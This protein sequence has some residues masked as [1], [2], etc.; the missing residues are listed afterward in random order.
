MIKP[1]IVESKDSYLLNLRGAKQL[2][3]I[4][5]ERTNWKIYDLILS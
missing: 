3:L 1:V 2:N 5:Q 4:G